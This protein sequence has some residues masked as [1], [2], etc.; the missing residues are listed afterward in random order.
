[1]LLL[2]ARVETKRN[3]R[4]AMTGCGSFGPKGSS[5]IDSWD[6]SPNHERRSGMSCIFERYVGLDYSRAQRANSSLTGL[7]VF[8]AGPT[9]GS[10][11]IRTAYSAA[12]WLRR[13]DL[14]GCVE[15]FFSPSLERRYR[16]LC[17]ARRVENSIYVTQC[18]EQVQ[19]YHVLSVLAE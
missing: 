4:L 14:D 3:R 5:G 19:C 8:E 2:L 7:R 6:V 1:M 13:S 11:E 15:R 9:K 17:F 16:Q 12:E 18:P 10:T